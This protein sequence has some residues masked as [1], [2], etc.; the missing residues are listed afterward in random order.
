MVWN[1][2]Q[3]DSREALQWILSTLNYP[4]HKGSHV[5]V[6]SSS[7][8]VA[9]PGFELW[10]LCRK[11]SF[12]VCWLREQFTEHSRACNPRCAW[13]SY[14]FSSQLGSA[15]QEEL[16]CSDQGLLSSDCWEESRALLNSSLST[17]V[18]HSW[19]G[20]FSFQRTGH[21]VCLDLWQKPHLNLYYTNKTSN[22]VCRNTGCRFPDRF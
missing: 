7:W 19:T 5:Y 17:V 21:Q 18:F 2:H 10:I 4:Q 16:P 22:Y 6:L 13:H 15:S 11:G 9:H 8:A 1:L 14:S 12:K 20:L 3:S